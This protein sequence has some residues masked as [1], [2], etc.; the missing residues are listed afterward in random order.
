MLGRRV[1]AVAVTLLGAR[2][3]AVAFVPGIAAAR[4]REHRGGGWR[5]GYDEPG[6]CGSAETPW[7]PASSIE[8]SDADGMRGGATVG[9]V[10]ATTTGAAGSE[11][12]SASSAPTPPN[13]AEPA[14]AES[15]AAVVLAFGS[16]LP[17]RFR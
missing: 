5:A 9:G 4:A 15:P 3:A 16:T 17:E 1:V 6:L 14:A 8:N 10:P 12:T 11:A 7:T 13:G 2:S